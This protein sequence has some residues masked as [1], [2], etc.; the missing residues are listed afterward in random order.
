MCTGLCGQRLC[1]SQCVVLR[2]PV[3][4]GTDSR[5]LNES[6]ITALAKDVMAQAP[7]KA[8][9]HTYR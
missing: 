4:Y 9:L 6:S 3:L 1:P 2:V 7:K 5:D 8:S